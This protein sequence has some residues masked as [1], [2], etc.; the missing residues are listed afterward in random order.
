[1]VTLRRLLAIALVAV[2]LA[3]CGTGGSGGAG[4]AGGSTT[5]ATSLC[6]KDPRAM[7]YAVG[8]SRTATGA[9]LKVT[10]VDA[11]PRPPG[12]EMNA[13]TVRV[14]DANGDPVTGATITLKPWMPDMGHGSSITPQITPMG[15]DGMYQVT[16]I[17]LFMPGI[18]SNTFT[19]KTASEPLATA[20]F[21]FCING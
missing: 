13:W 11:T 19:I 4:G 7:T 3:A 12:E 10:F 9:P 16:L 6:D 15:E 8:L 14:T 18:W 21:T 2:P 5:V 1:M 20:V 17:D